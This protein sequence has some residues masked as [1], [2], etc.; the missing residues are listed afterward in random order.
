MPSRE[1][2]TPLRSLSLGACRAWCLQ[3][4][5]E[6]DHV[7]PL[8]ERITEAG[9]ELAHQMDAQATDGALIDLEAQIGR[10]GL[11]RVEGGVPLSRSS[12]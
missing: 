5:P 9:A 3:V 7:E 11:K 1:D 8:L 12:R 4:D 6:P 10:C 2:S